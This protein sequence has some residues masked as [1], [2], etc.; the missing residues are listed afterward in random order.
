MGTIRSRRG[1]LRSLSKAPSDASG[2]TFVSGLPHRHR[3]RLCRARV[4]YGAELLFS[5]D[6]ILHKQTNYLLQLYGGYFLCWY[7]FML[8]CGCC[9]IWTKNKVNYPFIFE[10]DPRS[11]LDWRELAEF[12][13]MFLALQGFI[14][15]LNFSRSSENGKLCI[16]TGL[17]S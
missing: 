14:V 10:L 9:D 3:R 6:P 2:N 15:W 16:C 13:S 7:L 12:P 4:V 8:F 5:S 1:K 11:R 17:F